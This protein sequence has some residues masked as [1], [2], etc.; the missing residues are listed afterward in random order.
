MPVS[1]HSQN[2]LRTNTTI[3]GKFISGHWD[4]TKEGVTSMNILGRVMGNLGSLHVPESGPPERK[5]TWDLWSGES[6]FCHMSEL[7]EGNN[8]VST[9]S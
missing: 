5:A 1:G 6:V 7:V 4:G 3:C 8:Y 9:F 2:R